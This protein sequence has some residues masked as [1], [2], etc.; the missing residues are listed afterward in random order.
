MILKR[1][2]LTMAAFTAL[3]ISSYAQ[4][5]RVQVIHN[6]PDAVADSVDVY[7]NGGLLLD[8][9]AF[10]TATPFVDAPADTG[11]VRIGIAPKNS[12]SEADTIYSVTT[13][14]NSANTYILVA[15]GIVSTSG[16]NPAPAFGLNVYN[17]GQEVA[18]TAGNTDVLVVHGATDAPVV[19]VKAGNTTIVNDLAYG[20]FIPSYLNLPTADYVLDVTDGSGINSVR[21]YSAPLQTLNLHD[22]AIVVLASGFLNTPDNSYGPAFG[23]YVAL[24][25]GGALIPLPVVNSARVQVIHNCADLAAA[26]V[27]VYLNG[28]LLLDNFAFR[29]ASHFIDA[30]ADTG[31]VRIGIAPASSM[32]EADTIYSVTTTLNSANRYIIVAEGIVS[33]TGYNPAPAFG[34]NVYATAQELATNYSNTDVLVVHGATDAPVVDVRAGTTVLVDDI[35]YGTINANY[36]NLPTNDYV[37]DVTNAAGTTVVESYS[38]PLQSLDLNG[39]AITVLASG[40]LAPNLNSNGPAF[41]LWAALPAGGNLVMLPVATSV[42][43]FSAGAAQL[44]LF[45]NPATGTI[46]L[47]GADA[48]TGYTISDITGKQL[49]IGRGDKLDVSALA[50]GMYIVKVADGNNNVRV[51]KFT[52]Q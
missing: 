34:L 22:S 1:S 13:T 43:E 31:S 37:I 28:A 30:P 20:Q 25:E 47:L 3:S 12:S 48:N 10:R 51:G 40:F 9:F 49:M 6:C 15:E 26:T 29:T 19:D 7:L 50:P 36:L 17:M 32:S 33:S 11:S 5:A 42:K 45:P 38:A 52:K 8:N 44:G 23:L 16:Y 21:S 18:T 4:T 27:D 39:A 14:L 46:Q 24:P 41:G 2:L 35:A